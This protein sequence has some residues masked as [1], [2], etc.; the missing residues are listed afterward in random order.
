MIR[1][2]LVGGQAA[3]THRLAPSIN[4]SI[5]M[6]GRA[7]RRRSAARAGLICLLNITE[8]ASTRKRNDHSPYRPVFTWAPNEMFAVEPYC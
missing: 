2:N 6:R 8:P 3:G 1:Y 4:N 5:S 7:D